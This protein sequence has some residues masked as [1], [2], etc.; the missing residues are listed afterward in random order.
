MGQIID[1]QEKK[2]K[3][4]IECSMQYLLSEVPPSPP[5]TKEELDDIDSFLKWCE[6]NP[7][8]KTL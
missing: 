7:P 5:L 4:L 6:D 8:E 1:F 2:K 3:I